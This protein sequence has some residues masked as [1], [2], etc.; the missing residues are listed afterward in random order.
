VA[1]RP[2]YRFLQFALVMLLVAVLAA[3]TSPWW[4]RAFSYALIHEDPPVKSDLAVVLGGDF[5]GRRIEKGGDLVRQGFV[6]AALVSGPV[7]A[8]GEHE[9]DPEIAYAVRQG[10]PASL[11]I[12]FP[13][14]ARST[15]E[16]AS[17]IVAELRR[18]HVHH[19][20]LVTSEFHTGRAYRT[21]QNT[22]RKLGIS[23]DI[24]AIGTADPD[25]HPDSWW[26]SREGQ[27]ITFLE[28]TKTVA[29]VLGW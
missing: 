8:Y 4:L 10:Y 25:F 24:R 21:Y 5:L 29:A 22:T 26:R 6:P 7:G 23:I 11:F 15:Q 19:I 13:N 16:E 18:R 14:E 20:L 3:L 9:C 12:P 17:A 1:R 28:W 27:K 2:A